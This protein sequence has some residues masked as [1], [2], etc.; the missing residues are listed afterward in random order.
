MGSLFAA[1]SSC[2]DWSRIMKFVAHVSSSTRSVV[3]P[4][5][6]ASM[7]FAACDVEPLASRV[8]KARVSRPKGRFRMKGEMSTPVTW[9][10]SSAR[11]FTAAG[12]L[13]VDAHLES[14]QQRA[15][16]VEAAADDHGDAFA[17]AHPE[18]IASVR[19]L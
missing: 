2:M 6:R 9:R 15:L 13:V 5:S 3:A 7:M 1:T 17:D 12:H 10:P 18:H 8:V 16:A 14:L 4:V 11:I 19:E